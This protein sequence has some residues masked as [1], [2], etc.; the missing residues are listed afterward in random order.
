MSYWRDQLKD[1]W[2]RLTAARASYIDELSAADAIYYDAVNGE[3]GVAFP[4][5]TAQHPSND[6]AHVITMCTARKVNKIV[7]A[8]S[9]TLSATMEGYTFIGRNKGITIDLGSQDVDTSHFY[10]CTVTGAQGGTGYIYCH[11]CIIDAVTGGAMYTYNCDHVTSANTITLRSGSISYL[12]NPSSRAT[13]GWSAAS[14]SFNGCTTTKIFLIGAR[15]FFSA[16]LSTNAG[17]VMEV[18]GVGGCG[19]DT[20]DGNTAGSFMARGDCKF[21]TGGLGA[22]ETD[23]SIYA[24]TSGLRKL[25]DGVYFDSV[26]GVDGTNWPVG[27]A[28]YPSNDI[29]HVITM[30]TARKIKKIYVSGSLTLGATMDGYT[31]VGINKSAEITL[32]GQIIDNSCFYECSITGT[33]GISGA[34][35]A[36]NCSIVD[37][38]NLF[39]ATFNC[40]FA[41]TIT[42]VDAT[43]SN[44]VNPSSSDGVT[45]DLAT[46]TNV[47]LVLS[48]ASGVWTIDNSTDALNVITI[49]GKSGALVTSNASN[50]AGTITVRGDAIFTP[51]AGGATETDN[52]LEALIGAPAGVSLAADIAAVAAKTGNIPAVIYS[53]QTLPIA[54]NCAKKTINNTQTDTDFIASNTTGAKGLLNIDD[55][56]VGKIFLMLVARVENVYAGQNYLDCSTAT[57][58]QW[59]INLD[60]GGY[61]DLVNE[62]ADGQM[63][64]GDWNMYSQYQQIAVSYLFECTS[65]ITNIDGKIG[66]RLANARAKQASMNIT[67][68]VFLI[69]DYKNV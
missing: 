64:D 31:F 54:M 68:D 23:N 63:L 3:D 52:T 47:G 22:T 34:A 17:N 5:G 21:V 49:F 43:G 26:N 56:K 51:G 62:E 60:G 11:D 61:S 9:L 10:N 25:E 44:W 14:I 18:L 40:S 12:I 28:Q 59:Q 6:I 48:E 55:T 24:D 36:E 57:D 33:Q 20:S 30:C 27:T 69:V 15:G 50:T 46:H 8:S 42:P 65:Q 4:V 13:P 1:L 16:R 7:V 39:M 32:G 67:L 37:V 66:I 35:Y 58:N 19:F 45:I 53:R 41:G 2:N 38:T 29:A